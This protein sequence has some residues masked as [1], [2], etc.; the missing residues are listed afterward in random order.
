M[1]NDL[2]YYVK[3]I[4]DIFKKENDRYKAHEQSKPLMLEM[5]KDKSILFE[6]I[7]KNLEKPGFLLQKRIN[8]VI[9]LDIEIN[10]TISFIAHC[11]MPLPDKRND[12]SHQSIHH[13]GKLLLTSIAAWGSGYESVIFKKGYTIEKQSGITSMQIEKTYK[14]LFLNIEFIDINTPHVVFYPSEFSITYA[15]W[16]NVEAGASENLKKISFNKKYKKQLR[17]IIDT[18]GLASSLG[19]NINEYLDFY[20]KNGKIIALKNRV[21]YEVGSH[22]AF[23]NGFFS[24][25]QVLQYNDFESLKKS[26][27]KLPAMTQPDI[28]ILLTKLISDEHIKDKYDEIHLNIDYINFEKNTLLNSF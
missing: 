15:L 19:L 26:I 2:K 4:N 27:K 5:A 20:P 18:L 14:N 7:K 1:A 3:S 6:I 16:T 24:M 8:P 17:N 11:W 21:K 23:I 10:E 13:H 25:L 22:S 12:I 28:N 9:A